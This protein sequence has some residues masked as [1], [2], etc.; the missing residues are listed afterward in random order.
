MIMQDRL[1]NKKL[2]LEIK[3][4]EDSVA[5]KLLNF[6]K[7]NNTSESD[8][9]KL[10]NDNIQQTRNEIKELQNNINKSQNSQYILDRQNIKAFKAILDAR[11]V[12]LEGKLDLLKKFN[13]IKDNTDRV[14]IVYNIH[15]IYN[16]DECQKYKNLDLDI[17]KCGFNA[18]TLSEIEECAKSNVMQTIVALK[19][20]KK[21]DNFSD[22]T[23]NLLKEINLPEDKNKGQLIK[24]K[25]KINPEQLNIFVSIATKILNNKNAKLSNPVNTSVSLQ[26]SQSKEQ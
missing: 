22:D 14:K 1:N 25:T 3:I 17:I 19:K 8:I 11:N 5:F 18:K 13:L 12:I 10:F 21:F 16:S 4:P 23:K 15:G 20:H 24:F 6:K 7:I 26:K 9:K 2:E